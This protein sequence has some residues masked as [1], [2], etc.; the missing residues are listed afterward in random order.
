VA[1]FNP[2]DLPPETV[3]YLT[4]R[5]DDSDPEQLGR[6]LEHRHLYWATEFMARQLDH[7][8][9]AFEEAGDELEAA[10]AELRKHGRP[11]PR[12]WQR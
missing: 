7:D 6:W 3:K 4:T 10:E 8:Y 9:D 5:P 2:R 12:W 11:I 1:T